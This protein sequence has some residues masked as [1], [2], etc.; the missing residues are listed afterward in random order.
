MN[1]LYKGITL[2]FPLMFLWTSC[3]TN[4]L[5]VGDMRSHDT[6]IRSLQCF[7]KILRFCIQC[8]TIIF[9][10]KSEHWMSPW[11]YFCLQDVDNATWPLQWRHDGRDCVSNHRRLDC[12]LNRLLMRRSK[13][14]AKLRVTAFVRE[15]TSNRWI[16]CTHAETERGKYLHL[17]TS[18]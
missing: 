6:H 15:F 1:F 8:E 3:W 5:I 2:I 9:F 18:S 14:T 17:M 16:P 13:K 7:V 10:F 12:L 4:S 11:I